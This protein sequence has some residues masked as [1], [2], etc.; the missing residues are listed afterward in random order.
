MMMTMMEG[1]RVIRAGDAVVGVVVV[2]EL[3]RHDTQ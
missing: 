2:V 1:W 3:L